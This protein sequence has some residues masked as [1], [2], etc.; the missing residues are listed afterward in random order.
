MRNQAGEENKGAAYIATIR[1]AFFNRGI[2]EKGDSFLP[3]MDP[4]KHK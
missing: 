1:A 3:L 2:C 4:D